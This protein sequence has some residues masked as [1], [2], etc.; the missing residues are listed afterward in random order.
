MRD[1]S[2]RLIPLGLTNLHKALW[3]SKESFQ[4]E[5]PLVWLTY[6]WHLARVYHI[7][8][9]IPMIRRR[10]YRLKSGGQSVGTLDIL[11]TPIYES[12]TRWV[13]LDLQERIE[14]GAL[15]EYLM[16]LMPGCRLAILQTSGRARYL[17]D[18]ES[19]QY[20]GSLPGVGTDELSIYSVRRDRMIQQGGDSLSTAPE[21]F[22]RPQVDAEFHLIQRGLQT[23]GITGL[24]VADSWPHIGWGGWG[25]VRR[26]FAQQY[27]VL[28]SLKATENLARQREMEWFCIM[29][30]GSP[31]YHSACR[32]Y[33][34][35]GMKRLLAVDDFFHGEGGSQE[36]D[37]FLVYGKQLHSNT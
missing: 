35:Y 22:G 4:G 5:W 2:V 18:T 3:I 14:G 34:H 11:A 37:S 12:D 9:L 6:L 17:E 10:C 29:T 28:D 25:T 16:H 19:V 15:A 33:E 36:L 32:M 27:T 26:R 30:A 21:N 8:S 24:Y 23:V 20:E 13:I 7:P 1:A 31:Q